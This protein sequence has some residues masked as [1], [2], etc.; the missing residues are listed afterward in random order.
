SGKLE[1]GGGGPVPSNL[2]PV[3]PPSGV[4]GA[5]LIG[6]VRGMSSAGSS[7]LFKRERGS[8]GSVGGRSLASSPIPPLQ[9]GTAE[10]QQRTQAEGRLIHSSSIVPE[11]DRA[12][13]K[14]SGRPNEKRG[15]AAAEEAHSRS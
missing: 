3:G 4:V 12:W 13:A 2:C 6:S 1:S 15:D 5:W 8:P 11:S 9:A 14:E 7:G 10:V